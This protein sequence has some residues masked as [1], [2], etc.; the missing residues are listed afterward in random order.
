MDSE[1]AWQQRAVVWYWQ[2]EEQKA[3]TALQ[4]LMRRSLTKNRIIRL[5]ADID[6]VFKAGKRYTSSCF[7]LLVADN[8]LSYSRI[9]V[10]PVKHYGNSVQRNHIRRQVK[11]I[12]RVNQE[13]FS[14]GRDFAVVVRPMQEKSLTFQEKETLLLEL[15]RKSGTLLS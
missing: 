4:S 2:E 11:E 1:L 12:W 14:K 13:R 10:I 7:T 8:S 15:F 3:D 5:K 6:N 9:I